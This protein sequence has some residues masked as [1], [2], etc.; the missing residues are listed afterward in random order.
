M[1]RTGSRI[2]GAQSSSGSEWWKEG[3]WEVGW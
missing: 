2:G 1:S 3:V